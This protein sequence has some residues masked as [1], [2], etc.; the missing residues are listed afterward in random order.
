MDEFKVTFDNYG[1]SIEGDTELT[2]SQIHDFHSHDLSIQ[3]SGNDGKV[4][5]E[6]SLS[7]TAADLVVPELSS[8]T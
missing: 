2:P 6:R 4:H 3:D 8:A 1:D 7:N 5:T